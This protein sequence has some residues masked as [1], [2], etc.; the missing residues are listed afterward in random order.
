MLLELFLNSFDFVS[1]ED[2]PKARPYI[3]FTSC[4]GPDRQILFSLK[5][6]A[7]KAAGESL[8]YIFRLKPS[9]LRRALALVLPAPLADGPPA[10]AQARRETGPRAR[11]PQQDA[12]PARQ[13]RSPQTAAG[14]CCA[15][16]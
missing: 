16:A 3:F 13:K 11:E 4:V 10:D 15:R 8:L 12:R 9:A 1:T 2:G 14:R 7:T 5:A 6:C